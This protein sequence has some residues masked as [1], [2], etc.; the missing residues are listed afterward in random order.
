LIRGIAHLVLAVR[1]P[2]R[3]E[4]FAN[5]ALLG[6]YTDACRSLVVPNLAVLVP[7]VGF[8]EVGIAVTPI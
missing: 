5:R 7:L 2:A 1:S 4:R 6:A 8:F 3:Y